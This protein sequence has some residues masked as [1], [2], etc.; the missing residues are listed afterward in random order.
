VRCR[1]LREQSAQVGY[2]IP[3]SKVVA[4]RGGV[5]DIP[6]VREA[7]HLVPLSANEAGPGSAKHLLN[8]FLEFI[9][10]EFP[11]KIRFLPAL[12]SGRAP[13]GVGSRGLGSNRSVTV[14]SPR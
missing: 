7:P 14:V 12:G 2:R 3:H 13:L 10:E 5:D 11:W 8:L 1:A 9:H 6:A 4:P